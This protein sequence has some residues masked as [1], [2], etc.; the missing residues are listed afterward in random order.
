M[1][2]RC[3]ERVT[4]RAPVRI[5]RAGWYTSGML[6]NASLSGAFVRTR[7]QAPILSLVEIELFQAHVPAYVVRV[8]S[9]GL[10]LEWFEFAPAGVARLLTPLTRLPR[11]SRALN[12]LPT[13][14]GVRQQGWTTLRTE[15]G[16]IHRIQ[17]H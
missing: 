11:E 1:E 14:D 2:H 13:R 7:L 4:L 9:R 17:S 8:N 15:I 3:G 10:A 12:G 5:Q 16:S 6:V